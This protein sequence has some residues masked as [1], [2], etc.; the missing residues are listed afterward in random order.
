MFQVWGSIWGISRPVLQVW[1]VV[2]LPAVPLSFW[3]LS[4]SSPEW[5]SGSAEYLRYGFSTDVQWWYTVA[6]TLGKIV[7]IAW[8]W[9][10]IGSVAELWYRKVF[11]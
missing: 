4:P 7:L 5:L 2:S 6:V 10:T 8:S 3:S 9:R 11:P 1:S